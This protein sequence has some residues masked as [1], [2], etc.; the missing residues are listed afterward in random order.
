M[1]MRQMISD[2]AWQRLEPLLPGRPGNAGRCADN[3]R[4]FIEAVLWIVRVGAPWRDLPALFGKWGTAYRRF[5]RWAVDGIWA[6][7]V[8]GFNF[9][10]SSCLHEWTVR[11]LLEA[12][13]SRISMGDP[14]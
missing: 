3:N 10:G 7:L 4:K 9:D 6:K 1:S 13:R 12:W 5:R 11:D 8:S 14:S 2:A